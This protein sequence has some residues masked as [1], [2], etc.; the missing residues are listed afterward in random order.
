MRVGDAA[1]ASRIS[2]D[3]GLRFADIAEPRIA[4]CTNDAA[5]SV[6]E[7][8]TYVS[9][10]RAWVATEDDVVVGFV[11]VD[12]L[13]E[14]PH[15]EEVDVAVHAG[16]RGH[17]TRLLEAVLEWASERGASA[18]TLTTFRDVP[19][20]RPW[21]ERHGFRVLSEQEITPELAA[22][23]MSEDEEGLPADLR[24]VMRRALP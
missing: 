22:R 6:D 13:D 16:G 8:R 23:R 10:D 17:G 15:I 12:I 5:F 9:A 24:V 3:A 2:A 18:V 21:Y 20:N 14:V 11:I 19:W 7:L 4:A 1:I